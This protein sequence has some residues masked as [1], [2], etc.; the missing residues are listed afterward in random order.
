[1]RRPL[2]LTAVGAAGLT[3]VPAA[4]AGPLAQLYA[5]IHV[6]PKTAPSPAFINSH[7]TTG[8]PSPATALS[9]PATT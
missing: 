8:W 2:L 9:G 6:R 5:P 1:M 4:S 7:S 3:I